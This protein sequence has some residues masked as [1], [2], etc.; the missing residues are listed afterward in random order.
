M[1]NLPSPSEETSVAPRMSLGGRLVNVYATPGEVFE[2]VKAGPP[3]H[4]NWLVPTVLGCVFAII[5]VWVVFS[6]PS[7]QQ[8]MRDKQDKQLAQMVAS[9]KIKESQVEDV[10]AMMDKFGGPSTIKIFGSVGA[11]VASFGWLFLI[12]LGLWLLGTK[13]F[14]GQFTYF[15]AA[16]IT[17][18]AGMVS[19]IG[20]VIGMLL[21]VNF[22]NMSVTPGPSLLIHE[23][24]PANKLHLMLASVNLLTLWY[25]GILAI[26]LAR[27]SAVSV[28]KAAVWLYGAW[29]VIR[30]AIILLGAGSFGT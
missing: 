23:F 13:V 2:Q 8:Q 5:Y 10:R 6:Q 24:D 28:A 7:I 1:D 20:A 26:G 17:G 27:L 21:V 29:A 16:E 11:V 15:Q 25:I 19:V 30:L 3:S 18:L 9:G 14:K 22:G 4:A 12:A